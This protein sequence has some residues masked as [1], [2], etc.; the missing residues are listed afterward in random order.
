[1][2]QATADLSC[3]LAHPA[4][5]ID[6]FEQCAGGE[7]DFAALA[8]AAA[9]VLHSALSPA[10]VAVFRCEAGT[11]FAVLAATAPVGGEGAVVGTRSR[12]DRGVVGRAARGRRTD[13]ILNRYLV[14]DFVRN[15]PG[16][17]RSELAVPILRAGRGLGVVH[18]E[19][20]PPGKPTE[21]H[22]RAVEGVAERIAVLADAGPCPAAAVPNA[23]E[24]RVRGNAVLAALTDQIAQTDDAD[25]L[26]ERIVSAA[27]ELLQCSG[28]VLLRHHRDRPMLETVARV[29]PLP[30]DP[31][32]L[33]PTDTTLAGRVARGGQPHRAAEVT[34]SVAPDGPFGRGVPV[35]DALL[36]PLTVG[37]RTL[38]VLAAT[39]PV[40]PV[41][42]TADDTGLLQRFGNLA[43]MV[44]SIRSLGSL[45]ERLRDSATIAEVGRSLTG[46]LSLEEVYGLVTR[47]AEL[48]LGASCATIAMVT[49]DR[50]SLVLEAATGVLRNDQGQ[51]IPVR[52]SL[53]GWVVE[54][55]EAVLTPS[56]S[57]DARSFPHAVRQG[58]GAVVP[59][60][61]RAEIRGAL[62]VA[63]PEGAPC[64]T[65]EDLDMLRRLASYASI[66]IDN[67]QLYR[68]Q[69]ETGEALRARSR[70]LERAYDELRQSQERL[71][72][73][74]KMAALG[75]LTAG[76]A[77]EINSPLGSVL[78]ALQLARSYAE[79][80][81]ASVGDPEVT[82]DD[83]QAIAGD[84]LSVL[85]L[86]EGA[87]RKAAEF[88]RTIKGQ[89]RVDTGAQA[90]LFDPADEIDAMVVLM[91]HELR[92][93]HVALF[94]ELTR[95]LQ[96]SGDPAQFA[97]VLQNLVS[98][99]VDAYNGQ[100]GEVWVR[101]GE[102]DG[103]LVLE[104]EDRG[105]GISDEVGP[106][107]FDYL[108]TTKDVGQGT[109]LGLSMVH[110][111]VT[112][113]FHGEVE[114]RTHPG[115]GTTFSVTLPTP[116]R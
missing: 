53:L 78:N 40:A 49:E 115:A 35:R 81:R 30:L 43:G 1:M 89:T 112:S 101:L 59:L 83:H 18:L 93:R 91:Q 98:N 28:A 96:L 100:A 21:P 102:R 36:V 116:S 44:E 88:V 62:L 69:A 92:C 38:G 41:G 33:I 10:R 9:S 54:T 22:Q 42:F 75:R 71:V 31:G 55:N 113:H 45:R 13:Q 67:A 76:I 27:A 58:P 25:G 60:E 64:A 5:V 51:T 84:L 68:D 15:L 29:G 23:S 108:F 2:I 103:S 57:D 11:E 4:E 26:A 8:T 61:A 66:A 70:D 73:A 72:I 16:E 104:V 19:Y 109:G 95:G 107:V 3:H 77:H 90:Q 37:G 50:E 34:P 111:I 7:T 97:L 85:E 106:R 105:C 80:Y 47:A 24:R 46:P 32:D 86:G 65:E 6:R 20:D 48:I 87:T 82:P 12:L 17:T 94:T 79:E 110:S 56:V 74:E 114:F 14:P 39:D 99:A 63:R 52:G